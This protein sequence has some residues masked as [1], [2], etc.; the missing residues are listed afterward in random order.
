[1]D[2]RPLLRRAF[3]RR[4]TARTSAGPEIALV[5]AERDLFGAERAP[6]RERYGADAPAA[7]A[8]HLF[9]PAPAQIPGQTDLA[10]EIADLTDTLESTLQRKPG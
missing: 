8:M 5:D 6:E 10:A 9:A 4:W 1:M 7:E 2:G 3:Q